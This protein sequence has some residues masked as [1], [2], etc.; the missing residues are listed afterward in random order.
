M[1]TDVLSHRIVMPK[2]NELVSM[3]PFQFLHVLAEGIQDELAFYSID[4]D[5]RITYLSKSAEVVIERTPA[6]MVDRV[7]DDLLT[8]HV[9]NNEIRQYAWEV[10][11]PNQAKSGQCEF[12]GSSGKGPI[13][14][15]YWR[16]QVEDQGK[17][18]GFS[19]VLRRLDRGSSSIDLTDSI[20]A[21][22]LLARIE[23]LTP[24]EY[25]VI[26]MVVDGHMNKEAA[27][28]LGVAVR[29][30]ES[31]RSRAMLK[32]KANGLSELVQF[33]VLG[34]RLMASG[35]FKSKATDSIH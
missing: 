22:D 7:F 30:I 28:I 24:V 10:P 29:T 33:W 11:T 35:K 19:G 15:K 14:A 31:R 5:G 9:C 23:L 27:S 2:R 20:D 8:E 26:D 32:L 25:Q 6:Q 34:R 18:I 16:M 17:P 13:K 4:L 3:Q 12:R 21:A 1:P